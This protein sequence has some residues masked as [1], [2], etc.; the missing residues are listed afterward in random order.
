MVKTNNYFSAGNDN[1][2][3]INKGGDMANNTLSSITYG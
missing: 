3:G 2:N 1:F